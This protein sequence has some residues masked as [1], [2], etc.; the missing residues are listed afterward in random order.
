MNIC[1]ILQIPF[2]QTVLTM[3]PKPY[4]EKCEHLSIDTASRNNF[5]RYIGTYHSILMCDNRSP[6]QCVQQK[7]THQFKSPP[8]M[9][10]VINR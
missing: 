7:W 3:C 4:L 10:S 5:C 6:Q 2:N 8:L 9:S 1:N